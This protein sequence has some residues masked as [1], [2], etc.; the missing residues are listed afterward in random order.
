MAQYLHIICKITL[1]IFKTKKKMKNKE[2]DL[3]FNA[4]GLSSLMSFFNEADSFVSI[5]SVNNITKPTDDKPYKLE[6]EIPGYSKEDI[7]ITINND[8][9]L[10]TAEN[11]KRKFIK[12]IILNDKCDYNA[13][14]AKLENGILYIEIPIKTNEESDNIIKINVN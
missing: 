12:K 3:F 10:I 8:V 14:T 6:Y 7:N 5:S 1:I 4:F 11:V 9:L 2:I 13:V